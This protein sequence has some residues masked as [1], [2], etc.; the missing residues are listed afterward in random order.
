MTKVTSIVSNISQ[1]QA[2]MSITAC[3]DSWDKHCI[4]HGERRTCF[5]FFIEGTV[6][7]VSS[8]NHDWDSVIPRAVDGEGHASLVG[9]FLSFSAVLDIWRYFGAT[10]GDLHQHAV[11]VGDRIRST[12][13]LEKLW[14]KKNP[15]TN[16]VLFCEEKNTLGTLNKISE[17]RKWSL[18]LE[19]SEPEVFYFHGSF[20]EKIKKEN[21]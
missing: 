7:N 19:D 13:S 2:S 15:E 12:I 6:S 1:E 14:N 4:D 11:S 20:F 8:T 10:V 21:R 16:M 18:V 3:R 5:K 17:A 9:L